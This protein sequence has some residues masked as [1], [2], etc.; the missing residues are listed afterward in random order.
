VTGKR[1]KR[2]PVGETIGGI[3]V[4]FDQQIFRTTPPVQELIVKGQPV[5][6]LSGEDGS[7]LQVVFPADDESTPPIAPSDATEP[8]SSG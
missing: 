6:G 7:D 1:K 3:I 5:R 4:G 8:P 2:R